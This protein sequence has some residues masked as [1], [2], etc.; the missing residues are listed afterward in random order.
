MKK[1]VY[2][3]WYQVRL[4]PKCSATE[5]QL[6]VANVPVNFY[7]KANDNGAEQTDCIIHVPIQQKQVFVFCFVWFD[8]LRPI[9]NL[10]VKQGWDILGWTST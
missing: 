3:I 6:D 4:Q 7:L 10:S 2:E 9:N 5:I 8:S 1:F